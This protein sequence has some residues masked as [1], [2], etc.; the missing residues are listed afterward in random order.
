MTDPCT[1]LLDDLAECG[2]TLQRVGDD[3]LEL[4]STD[5]VD[6][7]LGD[8][9]EL[10]PRLL[11]LACFH[12]QCRVI[13][14]GF[15]YDD[16]GRVVCERHAYPKVCDLCRERM[17]FHGVHLCIEC[18]VVVEEGRKAMQRGAA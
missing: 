6:D 1:R 4:Q 13:E 9:R 17:A 15:Q 14:A 11:E 16:E 12:L 10:K 2:V 8:I 5:S 18:S 7:L 3:E